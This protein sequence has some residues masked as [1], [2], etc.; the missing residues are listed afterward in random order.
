MDNTSRSGALAN[1]T[2]H[3]F[4]NGWV[5]GDLY[6]I[7]VVDHKTFDTSGPCVI[8]LTAELYKAAKFYIRYILSYH[9]YNYFGASI[10]IREISLK[11]IFSYLLKRVWSRGS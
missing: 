8:S 6:N 10:Q 1:M 2:L 11:F 4:K 7:D 9:M 3:E 5:D